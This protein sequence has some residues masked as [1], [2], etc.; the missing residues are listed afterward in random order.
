MSPKMSQSPISIELLRFLEDYNLLAAKVNLVDPLTSSDAPFQECQA[1]VPEL[2]DKSV[3]WIETD[4]IEVP[5]LGVIG[6]LSLPVSEDSVD[7]GTMDFSELA[8]AIVEE[9]CHAR[10]GA[11]LSLRRMGSISSLLRWMRKITGA[12]AGIVW[13]KSENSGGEIFEEI[14][15][16]GVSGIGRDIPVGQG[17]IGNLDSTMPLKLVAVGS[18]AYHPGLVAQKQWKFCVP[19]PLVSD[20][21]VVGAASLYFGNFDQCSNLNS[22]SFFELVG[23]VESVVISMRTSSKIDEFTDLM[24]KSASNLQMGL[25]MI[26]LMHDANKKVDELE[27]A[28]NGLVQLLPKSENELEVTLRRIL[29]SRTEADRQAFAS[30]IRSMPNNT[31][32]LARILSLVDDISDSRPHRMS[33][34]DVR[35][36]VDGLGSILDRLSVHDRQNI[37]IKGKTGA[38]VRV[39]PAVLDRIIVNLVMNSLQWNSTQIDL[40]WEVEDRSD[41]RYRLGIPADRVVV[42]AVEDNGDGMSAKQRSECLRPFRSDR[43]GGTGLGLF[44]V[45]HLAKVNGGEVHVSS[46]LGRGTIVRVYFPFAGS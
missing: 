17:I 29:P 32:Y 16:S 22:N 33:K 12:S 13:I 2:S 3:E 46:E 5:V 31:N 10:P 24:A 30:L 7:P 11:G 23:H 38:L 44:V 1:T 6:I 8:I 4:F 40:T 36:S 35:K 37:R 18:E 19:I 25:A 21:D 39:A 14:D 27:T 43:V 26:G 45:D 42:L 41:S 28:V 9:W 34:V 15:S 20:G